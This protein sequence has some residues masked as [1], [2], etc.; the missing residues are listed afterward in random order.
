MKIFDYKFLIL[1]GLTLVVYFLYRELENVKKK[2]KELKEISN[3]NS[4]NQ[5]KYNN[6]LNENMEDEFQIPLPQKPNEN[7]NMNESNNL[8]EDNLLIENNLSNE[9]KLLIDSNNNSHENLEKNNK[10]IINIEINNKEELNLEN[11]E[12]NDSEQIDIYSNDIESNNN[13]KKKHKMVGNEGIDDRLNLD[14]YSN[15]NSET[16]EDL[17]SPTKELSVN[18]D[19][20]E[21]HLDVKNENK[22]NESN[23]HES[24]ESESNEN[25]SNEHESNENESNENESNEKKNNLDNMDFDNKN[26]I[27]NNIKT[28]VKNKLPELQDLAQQNNISTKKNIDGK[29][30]NKTKLELATEISQKKI[31]KL[32]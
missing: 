5:L 4:S 20:S 25:E 26:D 18:Y 12:S 9:N 14:N 29:M 31:S 30:K 13:E 27:E 1:L 6:K 22:E 24:N 32:I 7:D 21:E 11:N 19:S 23:E 2:V 16:S 28:L 10:K 8:N 17:F 15:D 3:I